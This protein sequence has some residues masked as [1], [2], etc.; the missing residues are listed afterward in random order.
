MPAYLLRDP[1]IVRKS[2]NEIKCLEDA[3]WAERLDQSFRQVLADNL[4]AMLG[5]NQGYTSAS[6]PD[7]GMV[8][9]S[10]EVKQFDVD[11]QGRGT[12][13][14]W[15]H[16]TA[17]GS[18]KPVKGGQTRLSRAGPSPRG[19]P[20]AIATTLSALTADFSQELAQAIHQSAATRP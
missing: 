6:E 16:L 10:V 13:I 7:R 3:L 11:T 14:A 17:P 8:R 2:A 20:Q 18:D 5:S 1:L 9:V 4:S 15:W 12:L 19:N